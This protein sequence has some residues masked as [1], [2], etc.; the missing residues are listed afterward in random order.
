MSSTDTI[1]PGSAAR[2]D[3]DPDGQQVMDILRDLPVG[4]EIL[5]EYEHHH[6]ADLVARNRVRHGAIVQD[7][8]SG[9]GVRAICRRHGC[10]HHTVT[11][12][13]G[14]DAELVATVKRQ[15]AG[16]M[17]MI[18]VIGSENYLEALIDKTITPGQIPVGVGIFHDKRVGLDGSPDLRI[19]VTHEL[20]GVAAIAAEVE[21]MT[22]ADIIDLD[23]ELIPNQLANPIPSQ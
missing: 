6:T 3:E 9:V 19:T 10:S 15:L 14:R 17:L 22:E 7:I 23:A 4:M 16:T 8:A 18:E 5:P 12:I 21:A 13:I 1:T 2:I 11:A 20:L